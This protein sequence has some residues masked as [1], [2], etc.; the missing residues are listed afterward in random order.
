MLTPPP[1]QP[2]LGR[3]GILDARATDL[4]REARAIARV[5]NDVPF[6]QLVEV[7]D[8]VGKEEVQALLVMD[9]KQNPVSI[10]TRR[11][12][13]WALEESRRYDVDVDGRDWRIT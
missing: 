5:R 2:Y 6:S 11:D 1:N 13:M 4:T 12:V 3:Y 10:L 7:L 9:Y 8:Q